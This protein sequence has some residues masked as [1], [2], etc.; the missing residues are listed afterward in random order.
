[1]IEALTKMG[2]PKQY[3]GDVWLLLIFLIASAI[4]ILLVKKRNLGA[5]LVSIYVAYAI[6]TKSFFPFIEEPSVKLIYFLVVLAVL[7][8]LF[9]RFF[10]MGVGGGK[11]GVW[12]KI[13]LV[14]FSIIGLLGSIIMDW[15]SNKAVSE[16]FSP[17]SLRLFQT[18]QAQLA[19][20]AIPLVLMFILVYRRM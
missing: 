9:K 18:D 13:A 3:A 11:A 1:M 12:T 8:Q 14:S 5:M 6:V 4:L 7:F 16:F 19:W 20:M 17:L 10:R 15:F 2:V